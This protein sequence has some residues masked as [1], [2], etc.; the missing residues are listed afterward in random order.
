MDLPDSI[1]IEEFMSNERWGRR[2][3]ASSRNPYTCGLTG[4]T[5][6]AADVQRRTSHLARAIGKRLGFNPHEG[7]EWD[8]VVCL[9]SFNTI[10]YIPFTHAVHRLSGIVTPASAAYSHQ[11]LE[12]QLRTSGASAL[13]TCVA[14]LDNARKAAAAVGIPDERIF[15]LALPDQPAKAAKLPYP[16]IDDLVEEGK[17]LPDVAPLKWTPGQGARQAAYLCFSSGTSG[18]PKAV[19]VSHRNVI[20][21]VVQVALFESVSR[22]ELS[23]DTQTGLGLLPFSHIYGLSLVAHVSQYRGDEL[24]VMPRFE[25]V[26]FLNAVQKYK[27]EQLSVVPPILIQM[28]SNQS[29]C[30]KYDLSS[31]RLVYS[32]AAPL[33]KETVDDLLKVYPHW[34]IG[35][36]YGMT[37]ASPVVVSTSETDALFGSSGSLIPGT[38]AKIVDLEGN[39]VTEHEARGELLVQSPSVVLGYLNNEKANA[40]T[41]VWHDDGR[42]LRTGDEV[43]VRKSTK[44][45]EHFVIVDRIKELIKVK[46][47]QV[48][49]AELEGHLLSHPSVADCAVIPVDDDR[50][51]EVPKAFVV[52]TREAA[53]Q[54][55]SQVSK[56]LH[57]HVEEHKARHKWLK[58]GIEFIDAVPK[59]ASGKILRRLLRDRE[60]QA[61][62]AQ[63]HHGGGDHDSQTSAEGSLDVGGTG[64]GRSRGGSRGDGETT[65][66]SGDRRTGG[67][68][69]RDGGVG[70]LGRDTSLGDVLNGVGGDGGNGGQ[71]DLGNGDLSGDGDDGAAAGDGGSLGDAR[72]GDGL[73]DNDGGVGDVRDGGSASDGDDLGDLVGAGGDAGVLGDEGSADTLEE[74]D[75]LGNDVVVVTVGVKALEDL[76]DELL[77]GAVALGVGVVLALLNDVKEG[78]QALGDNLGARKRLLG[79]LRSLGG[80]GGLRLLRLLRLLGGLRLLGSL[81]LLGGLG[82]LRLLGGLDG[83]GD[84]LSDGADG[85]A[86]GN[87]HGDNSSGALGGAVRDLGTAAGDGLDGGGEDSRG[88]VVGGDNGAGGG[89]GGLLGRGG[90]GLLSGGSS[91]LNGQLLRRGGSLS[92]R[93]SLFSGRGGSLLSR[94]GSGLLSGR[95]GLL[96]GRSSLFSRRGRLLSRGG[97]GLLSGGSSRLNGQLLRR[98]GSLSRRSSLFSGRSGGLLSRR[99]S[100]LLSGR[101]GFLSRGSGGL[102]G[103]GRSGLLN[104]DGSGGLDH[105]RGGRLGVRR[106]GVRRLR[107]GRLGVRRLVLVLA[108][109]V[110]VVNTDVALLLGLVRL[111]GV[112]EA[113]L[114]STTALGV[115][116]GGTTGRALLGLLASRAVGHVVVELHAAVELDGDVELLD[117]EVLV[118][119]ALSALERGSLLLVGATLTADDTSTEGTR[120]KE[121]TLREVILRGPALE[122]EAVILLDLTI[123]EVLPVPS[124]LLL[125]LALVVVVA[126]DREGLSVVPSTPLIIQV[127][128]LLVVKSRDP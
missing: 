40:E 70:G 81:R 105:S 111:V 20:A 113:D 86:D 26:S 45:H 11:E 75:G 17:D 62:K 9:Y 15:L 104:R 119:T 8:R 21:N 96:C 63:H 49:P 22:K 102:D 93:S 126:R 73:D 10:D 110:D 79:L 99:G 100:G 127:S 67:D 83:S 12:H 43:L 3:I 106:L 14:L 25:L 108:V 92:R 7:T 84:G 90:G 121:I 89:R 87:G 53:A 46:G 77:L 60:R 57:R 27:I 91:R 66:A 101:S 123:G 47:H 58:G 41:F 23:I 56:D 37:E 51:G 64:D 5:F 24:V 107:V 44:G 103:N 94:G 98:G 32:G 88:G 13:F 19:M 118:L 2:A 29:E 85:G 42:W 78:V 4:R 55:E 39:E 35:Q 33:S 125:V 28:L 112:D 50:A 61:R 97:G 114:L 74:G 80:L 30:K 120:S 36:G 109:E 68:E 72:L 71:S 31:V 117:G 6:S 128:C 124:L 54:P 52:L 122:V 38:I 48:A 69:G 34:H 95:G 18:L 16:T 116:D 65:S 115:V 1:T 76:V 59:S 82:L